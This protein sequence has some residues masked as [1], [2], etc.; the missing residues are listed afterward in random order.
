MPKLFCR[1][2]ILL[3]LL[4]AAFVLYGCSNNPPEK[5]QR[6][7]SEGRQGMVSSA[8]PLATRAGLEVLQKGGNAFDAAVAVAAALNVTEPMMSGIGGYGTILIYS[9]REKRARFLNPSGRMPAELDSD[10][11]RP[12]TP[13][14]MQNRRGAK[15]VSTPGNVNAWEA[16]WSEYGSKDWESLFKP[17]ATYAEEGFVID[18]RTA[19]FIDVSFEEF[20][21]YAKSIYGRNGEPLAAGDT[22]VQQDLGSSL[23]LI[24]SRGAEAFHGGTLGEAVDRK[25]EETGGFLSLQDL[26]DNR[27]EW[28]EPVGIS[29]RGYRV[30]TASPPANSWPALL[31]LGIMQQYDAEAL[32]H[33]SVDYLH[34]YAEATKHAFWARLRWAGDPEVEPPPLD[35][36]LSDA[37]W[38]EQAEGIPADSARPFEPPMPRTS[39]ESMHTTHFVV[40]DGEGNVVSAT[41]TLGNLFGAKI[42]PE[43][44][45]IWLNNSLQYSTFEPKGNPMDAFP[46]RHKLSGDVPLFVMRDGRPWIA[47]GTPGGHT[48][49]QNVPQIVMNMIDFG[50]NIGDAIAAPKITFLEPDLIGVEQAFPR[51]IL[52]GLRA[53]GHSLRLLEGIGNAH[54][55]TIRYDSAGMP[56]QFQGSSD[57]RGIGSARGY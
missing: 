40:A 23:R 48:I 11:F 55:L 9:A 28:W 2:N 50:M 33:N 10:Q 42:M 20:S 56:M 51:Q 29:Y 35:R 27:A 16:M 57:P 49:A 34:R 30:V 36:L 26:E 6:I 41:Q 24:A 5:K 21:E 19:F 54:G 37:Y 7:P 31:R 39:A 53:K 12:P 45:G 22:L 32:G 46:G 14:Y 17:A 15:A 13:G 38:K 3:G 47:V 52:E 44:T 43:G 18:E 4:V 25:M 8:H 1:F